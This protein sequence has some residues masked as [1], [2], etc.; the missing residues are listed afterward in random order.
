MFASVFF[1]CIFQGVVLV[2]VVWNL[3]ELFGKETFLPLP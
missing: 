1:P 2:E 3:L